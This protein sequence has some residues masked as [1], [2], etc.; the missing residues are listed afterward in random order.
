M[1]K[2][3]TFDVKAPVKTRDEIGKLARAFNAMA[4]EI[5]AKV[6]AM[7]QLNQ[8]LQE[9]ES[10]YRTL[11]DNLPQRIF[12]KNRD[13]VFISCNRNFAR[14]FGTEEDEIVGKTDFDFFSKK[15]G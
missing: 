11:V 7:S 8:T 5:K 2:S 4:G 3:G 15:V 9:S 14:D 12:L 6:T 13:L 1:S 10:K